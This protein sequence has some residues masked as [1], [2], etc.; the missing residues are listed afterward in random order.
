MRRRTWVLF[1]AVLSLSALVSFTT[2]CGSSSSGTKIRMVNAMPDEGS[3][4]LL[5]DTKSA[6]TNVAYGAG[7]SYVSVASGSRQLQ[8][9]PTGGTTILI[10]RTDSIASGSNLTL[11]SLNISS[12]PSSMLLTDDNSAPTS[13]NFKLR[14]VNASPGMLTQDV[15]VVT[16]GSDIT[17]VDATF[18]GLGFG[19]SST[20]IT[21]AAGDYD[22]IFTDPGT[23]FQNLNSGKL[24][25]AT[26]QVRTL[27][28]LNNPNAGGF[29]STLLTDKN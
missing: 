24:T 29:E 6:A 9:E 27:L 4:D 12:N 17:S 14:V 22:V 28:G 21:L 19:S 13:G 16:D 18:S 1:C 7:S 20:Y 3:L 5:I 8:V 23:K 10:D 11:V 2:G 15:Y 25:F 26:G